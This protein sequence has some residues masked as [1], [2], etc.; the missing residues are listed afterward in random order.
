MLALW[1]KRYGHWLPHIFPRDGDKE[2]HSAYELKVGVPL[3]WSSLDFPSV[4]TALKV[5]LGNAYDRYRMLF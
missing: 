4:E 5:T 2:F 3:T 1:K